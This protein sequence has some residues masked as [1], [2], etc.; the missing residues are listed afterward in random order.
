MSSGTSDIRRLL[1]VVLTISKLPYSILGHL[2]GSV[3][4]SSLGF[5]ILLFSCFFAFSIVTRRTRF[6]IV[7]I[8]KAMNIFRAA[9]DLNN[10]GVSYLSNGNICLAG[11]SLT[12]SLILI[13]I[14]LLQ[15]SND[16]L[17][18]RT[19]TSLPPA[20]VSTCDAG[21]GFLEKRGQ[22]HVQ[23]M[24]IPSM[25]D[26]DF[27]IFN[28]A[29]T[30]SIPQDEE[31]DES[32]YTLYLLTSACI[33]LNLA[34]ASHL[35]GRLLKKPSSLAKAAS[36]YA[37]A[38]KLLGFTADNDAI[39][40]LIRSSAINNLSQISYVQADFRQVKSLLNELS[41][42]VFSSEI[43]KS[44]FLRSA[45][46]DEWQGVAMNIMRLGSFDNAPAA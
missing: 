9:V 21:S 22:M 2:A 26:Q 5:L 36:L 13:K 12:Q 16:H 10:E 18:E 42:L 11:K 8:R 24:S 3:P 39:S 19:E 34:L 40:F 6:L 46:D 27:F 29:L 15:V 31:T 23:K 4:D 14:Q 37:Y 45:T 38:V 7:P 35:Q 30:I 41:S 43:N 33:I 44:L 25:N 20:P 28:S 32:Y 1:S 17:Q